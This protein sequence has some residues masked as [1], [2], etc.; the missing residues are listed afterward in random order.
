MR[1][2]MEMEM[3]EIEALMESFWDLHDKISDAIHIVTRAHFLHTVTRAHFLH[4]LKSLGKSGANAA[5]E[6]PFIGSGTGAFRL[7]RFPVGNGGWSGDGGGS[8][9]PRCHQGRP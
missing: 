4:T 9:E 7:A 1:W 6:G 2:E 3:E 8:E 5:E